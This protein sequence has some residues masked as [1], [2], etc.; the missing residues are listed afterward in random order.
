V[1]EDGALKAA[2]RVAEDRTYADVEDDVFT[3]ASDAIVGVVHPLELGEGAVSA[4]TEVLG[5]YEIIQPFPQLGR[6]VYTPTA[7]ERAGG[8][9]E[10]GPGIA[11]YTG[12]IFALRK[13]GWRLDGDGYGVEAVVNDVGPELSVHLVF[14]PPIYMENVEMREHEVVRVRL[15][16]RDSP[17]WSALDPVAFSEVV[18]A[19]ESLRG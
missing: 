3:L 12:R 2:F 10:R 9:L 1:F 18:L 17:T 5:D 16:G 15:V 7:G 14:D 8:E 13:R 19:V 4:W 11:A 6:A